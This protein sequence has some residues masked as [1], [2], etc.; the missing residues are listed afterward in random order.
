MHMP[1]GDFVLR[2]GSPG[3]DHTILWRDHSVNLSAMAPHVAVEFSAR[4]VS[5]LYTYWR[6][7]FPHPATPQ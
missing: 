5:R 4:Q 1:T 2:I 7:W 3:V 6:Q